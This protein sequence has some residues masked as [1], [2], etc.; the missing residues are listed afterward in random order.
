MM[1]LATS[2]DAERFKFLSWWSGSQSRIGSVHVQGSFFFKG[3]SFDSIAIV[4]FEWIGVRI[5]A[6]LEVGK[7]LLTD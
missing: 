3:K 7:V 6:G 4:F 5:T 2:L 1:G